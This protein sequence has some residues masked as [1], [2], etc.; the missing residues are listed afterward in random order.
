MNTPKF[1]IWDARKAGVPIERAEAIWRKAVR[2]ATAEV[3]EV[4][5]SEF[6]GACVEHFH[7]LL[8]DEQVSLCSPCVVPLVRA[9]NR[10]WHLPLV[11]VEDMVSAMTLN[12]QRTLET[13]RRAA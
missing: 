8:A 2:E 13:L 11:A 3:D 6:W 12:W 5:S 4:G 7:H 10:M 9:Q 1:L